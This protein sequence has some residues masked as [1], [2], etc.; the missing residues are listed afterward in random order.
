[1]KLKNRFLKRV[2][3]LLSLALIFAL[4]T[5]CS[6]AFGSGNQKK[7]TETVVS[8]EDSGQIPETQPEETK[9][10]KTDQNRSGKT[11]TPE[12]DQEDSENPSEI[13]E[14][15]EYSSKEEVAE[16][17]HLYGHLPGNYITKSEA[18]KL[19]W[20][21]SEGNLWEVAPG[22]SIGGDSFGNREGLLPDKKGRKYY[23]CDIDYQGGYRDSK[24]IIYSS[25]ALVYYTEDHYQSFEQLYGEE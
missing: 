11:K 14:D 24:R 10:E 25:D 17:L 23:E 20:V 13:S 8:T 16:Y 22:K 15:G 6:G 18:K 5:G 12:Q 4:G 7:Q 1:M 9:Q 21:S 2:V 19:G 3:I